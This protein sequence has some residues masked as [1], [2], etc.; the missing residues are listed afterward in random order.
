[1]TEQ[2]LQD[3]E[4]S[5]FIY[6]FVESHGGIDKAAQ[7]LDRTVQPPPSSGMHL[8]ACYYFIMHYYKDYRY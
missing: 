3:E 8:F 4:T 7:E 2:Q 1:M 5:Q 6:D